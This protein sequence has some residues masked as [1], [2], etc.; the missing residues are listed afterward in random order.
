V[1]NYCLDMANGKLARAGEHAAKL[2]QFGA[3]G[4][5]AVRDFQNGKVS[6]PALGQIPEPV[7]TGFLKRLVEEMQPG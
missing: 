7:L 2:G 4:Q 1:V 6:E 3:A 5:E